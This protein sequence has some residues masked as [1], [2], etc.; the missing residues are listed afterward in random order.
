MRLFALELNND[1]KGI[2]ERKSYIE[3]LIAQLPSPDLVLL[4]ELALCSYMA[5]QA[6]WQYAADGGQDSSAWAMTMA[7]KYHTYLG[8]GYIDYED[9]DYFNRYLIAGKGQ[10]YG[11]I[12]KSEA[13]S[14]VFKRGCFESVIEMPFGNVALAICYDARRRHFYDNI[15][16]Q[17][18]VLIIF[19]H[20]S[21]ADPKK[22]AEEIRSRD[23]L[24][25]RYLEAFDLPVVY[26]NSLGRLEYM[27]GLMGAMM[28]RSGFTMNGKSKIYANM[29]QPIDC[30]LKGAIGI[31]IDMIEKGRQKDIRFYGEDMAKGNFFFRHV[32]LKAD[33]KAGLRQY[34]KNKDRIPIA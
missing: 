19:P 28:K 22:E 18:L 9:G 1:I 23:Y 10:V 3:S 32:I 14:A 2:P 6:A 7:A 8:V 26:V 4:P 11:I 5:S 20:G 27:P 16:D 15:K 24:C 25:E 21:P 13:E 31:D 34:E 33:I 29:G 30:D 17:K 12:T